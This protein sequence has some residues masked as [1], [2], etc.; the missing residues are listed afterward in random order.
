MQGREA[1]SPAALPRSWAEGNKDMGFQLHRSE[2]VI[3]H[4]TQSY[5]SQFS[6]TNNDRKQ[7]Q[8]KKNHFILGSWIEKFP[9]TM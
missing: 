2:L 6:D 7:N 3:Q 4:H 1:D 9:I 5:W 8:G